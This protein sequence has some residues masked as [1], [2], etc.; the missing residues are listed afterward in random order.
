MSI[1]DRDLSLPFTPPAGSTRSKKS[2]PF[3]S[4]ND[5]ERRKFLKEKKEELEKN[6][7]DLAEKVQKFK[8]R[9]SQA[10][11]K[12]AQKRRNLPEIPIAEMADPQRLR[13][14]R[15][16]RS[17]LLYRPHLWGN[18]RKILMTGSAITK[19]IVTLKD[20]TTLKNLHLQNC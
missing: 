6:Q 10:K 18:R 16:R 9:I 17:S 14:T 20:S 1:Y 3:Y 7:Q 5:V 15:T 11:F 8:K 4:F 19:N 2:G 13:R 12:A